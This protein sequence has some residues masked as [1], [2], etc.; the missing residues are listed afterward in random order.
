MKLKNAKYKTTLDKLHKYQIER[1]V[2]IAIIWC[3][4]HFGVR[5]WA[6]NVTVDV[7]KESIEQG[8]GWYIAY[9]HDPEITINT[10]GNPQIMDLID[11]VIHEY[12]HYLQPNFQ[13]I[14]DDL[15][16]EYEY[17]NHPLELEAKDMA[18][19][20]RRKCFIYIK[21]EINNGKF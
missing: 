7:V 5:K 3:V 12:T 21:K 14:Y 17:H 18:K 16:T 15:S 1:I 19:K 4:D 9:R 8:A 20:N 13:E 10:N 11:T 2:D 6:P